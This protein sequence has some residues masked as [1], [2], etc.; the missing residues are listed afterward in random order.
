MLLERVNPN[1]EV[2]NAFRPSAAMRK[3]YEVFGMCGTRIH[4]TGFLKPRMRINYD[5]FAAI[6]IRI[7]NNN[8][9][10]HT[11]CEQKS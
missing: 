11:N 2:T 10:T 4:H 5:F 1:V 9:Y 8:L 3:R 6:A 7:L